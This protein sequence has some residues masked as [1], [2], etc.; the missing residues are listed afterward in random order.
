MK[1]IQITEFGGPDVMHLVDLEVPTP[2]AG[3][4]LITVSAIGINAPALAAE[5]GVTSSVTTDPESPE[6]R[7]MIS[8]RAALADGKIVTVAIAMY[9]LHLATIRALPTS[10]HRG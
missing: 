3:Q 8:L 4:D 5:R 9:E 6:Y 10:N 1:A 2:G 7:S